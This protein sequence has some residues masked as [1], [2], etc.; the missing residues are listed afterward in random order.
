[1]SEIN[2]RNRFPSQFPEKIR[3]TPLTSVIFQ[4]EPP[5]MT[6]TGTEESNVSSSETN[7]LEMSQEKKSL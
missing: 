6:D 2:G 5:G 7:G 4:S 1:M 3:G